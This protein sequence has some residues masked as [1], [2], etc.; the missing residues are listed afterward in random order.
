MKILPTFTK[1]SRTTLCNL[2][3]A[4]YEED[5]DPNGKPKDIFTK[6]FELWS[7][8]IYLLNF[9]KR[10]EADL[11]S[12]FWNGISILEAVDQVLDEGLDFENELKN[13]ELQ[14]PGYENFILQDIFHQLHKYEF[15]LKPQFCR[16]RKGKPNYPDAMLRLYAIELEEGCM[17]VSGGAIKL[18]ERMNRPHLEK[19]NKRLIQV[20]DFLNN[21]GIYSKEGLI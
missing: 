20:Q 17:V 18:T 1:Q 3:A 2:W 15:S 16:F 5:C 8:R 11:A 12:P 14:M 10:H 9:F 4:C 19:E 13:I 6:V 21:E 7:D